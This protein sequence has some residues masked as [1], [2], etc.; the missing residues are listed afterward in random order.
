MYYI[1]KVPYILGINIYVLMDAHSLVP[2]SDGT[3]L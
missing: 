2:I 1:E 3:H